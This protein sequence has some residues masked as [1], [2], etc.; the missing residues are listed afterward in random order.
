MT[1]RINK[2]YTKQI[3]ELLHRQFKPEFLNRIDETIIFERLERDDL[4]TIVGYP[5]GKI[6]Q[7]LEEKNI[8][9]HIRESAKHFSWRMVTTLPSVQ[10][11]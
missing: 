5:A 2:R 10:D 11:P 4:L 8:V 3:D 7:R 1:K 9:L 6:D